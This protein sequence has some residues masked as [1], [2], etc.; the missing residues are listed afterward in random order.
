MP[1][2]QAGSREVR[3]RWLASPQARG[4][5]PVA[6]VALALLLTTEIYC[7]YRCLEAAGALVVRFSMLALPPAGEAEGRFSSLRRLH[8]ASQG[9][10]YPA[11]GPLVLATIRAL[12]TSPEPVLAAAS[13][14]WPQWCQEVEP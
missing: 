13:E 1:L 8:C 14:S 6:G 5:D 9:R 4:G 3:H 10:F 7:S 2:G 12:R 11:E